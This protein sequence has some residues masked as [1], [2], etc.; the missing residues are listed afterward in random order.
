MRVEAFM[1]AVKIGVSL[2]DCNNAYISATVQPRAAA[3]GTT[4][5]EHGIQLIRS[6]NTDLTGSRVW[7]WNAK[8]SKWEVGNEY[9]HIA[10]YGNCKG[11]ILNDYNYHYLTGGA[12]DIREIIYTDTPSNFDSLIIIQ[13][14]LTRWFK[15]IDYQPFFNNGVDG[16]QRLVLKSEQDALFQ[17]D[18]IAQF[19]NQ[20]P[21]ATDKDGSVFFDNGYKLGRYWEI[22]GTLKSESYS[23]Y[24]CTG[25]IKVNG[26]SLIRVRGFK[27]TDEGYQRVIYFDSGKNKTFHANAVLMLDDD[28]DYFF[29]YTEVEDGFDF[30]IEHSPSV[31][32]VVFNFKTSEFSPNTVITVDEEIVYKQAGFLADGIYVKGEYVEGLGD[33]YMRQNQK[34]INISAESTDEQFPT[35]KAVYSLVSG[36]L[37]TYVDAVDT[38][39]GGGS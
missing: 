31:A 20:L 24:G 10:L 26:N 29:T 4:Y 3:D 33:L 39:I 18:Q 1:D 15:P 27:F 2:E 35:A 5:A 25:F 16:D 7:D 23:N 17:T 19:T 30:Q 36:A 22:D 11:T 13:E 34:I 12:K 9:Q 6:E 14:P 37:G 21:K 28:D 32:Y 8:T 38:L